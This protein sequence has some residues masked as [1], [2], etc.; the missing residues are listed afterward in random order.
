MKR[1]LLVVT[2]PIIALAMIAFAVL[3]EAEYLY[4]VVSGTPS[5]IEEWLTTFNE[6]SIY[7]IVASAVSGF[8]W[9]TLAQWLF[10][11]NDWTGAGKRLAWLLLISLPVATTVA[12]ILL[13]PSAQEG[14]WWAYFFYLNS[15]IAPYYL[16]TVL[17][18]PASFKYSPIGARTLRQGW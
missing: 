7:I 11:L 1:F 15:A 14:T 17:F 10:H 6:W 3:V 4:N 5:S 13:T 18:S 2:M 16:G 8:L 12:A 9:Y